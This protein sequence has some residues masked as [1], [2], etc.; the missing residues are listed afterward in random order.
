MNPRPPLPPELA[1]AVDL[2]PVYAIERRYA[3][4][5]LLDS[6]PFPVVNRP[7]RGRSNG[8]KPFQMALLTQAGFTVP[9]WLVT[10][11][12]RAAL[13][14][15][16]AAPSGAVYKATS[17]LRSQV[18]LV[19]DPLLERL[20]RGT[21]PVVLQHF[22]PGDDVRVHVVGT[23]TFATV[24]SATGID[25]RFSDAEA[26]YEPTQ[27]PDDVVALCLSFA[28]TE[29]LDLAGFDFRRDAAGVWWCLEANP[30]P[31]FL[32]YEAG[33]G[34]AIGD[35]ILDLMAPDGKAAG[36]EVSPLTQMY[37]RASTD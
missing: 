9:P 31:T 25:Y 15:L 37:E 2:S 29:G 33:S 23:R 22:V 32:P 21:S 8:S 36:A 28:E 12:A 5:W 19:D 10:N 6:A 13:S 17:G 7:S 35:A 26:H 3:L 20:A 1:A 16:E 34:H 14:F 30:V 27:A 4:H 11:H 24:V 18:R